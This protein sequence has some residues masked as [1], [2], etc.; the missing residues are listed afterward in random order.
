MV[1]ETLE[2]RVARLEQQMTLVASAETDSASLPRL[3]GSRL[4]ACSGMMR[5][6]RI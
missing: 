2:T 3:I 1:Q 6:S 5:L 4:W